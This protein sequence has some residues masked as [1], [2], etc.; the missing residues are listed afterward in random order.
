[1]LTH[2]LFTILHRRTELTS[3][4]FSPSYP[5]QFLIIISR[6]LSGSWYFNKENQ[7]PIAGRYRRD[8]RFWGQIWTPG[9]TGPF[10]PGSGT[11][12][13]SSCGCR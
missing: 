10:L 1:V 12:N 4:I 7:E 6:S 5:E 13:V 2:S 8:F 3:N 11:Q 9:R